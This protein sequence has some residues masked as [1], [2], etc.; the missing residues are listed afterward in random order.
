MKIKSYNVAQGKAVCIY[1][2]TQKKPQRRSK[3]L[4]HWLRKIGQLGQLHL[5]DI[6]PRSDSQRQL[7]STT[8]IL[9]EPTQKCKNL[10][11][12]DDNCCLPGMTGYRGKGK[13]FLCFSGKG[14][15]E[16]LPWRDLQGTASQV[17]QKGNLIHFSR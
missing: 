17:W 16:C 13:G 3:K 4:I 7:Q 6:V 9:L 1:S 12:G 5:T 15:H 8:Q 11:Q 10:Q 14:N 2:S